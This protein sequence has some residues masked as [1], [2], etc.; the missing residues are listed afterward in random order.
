M[1]RTGWTLAAVL[2]A[3]VVAPAVLAGDAPKGDPY[4]LTTC[5]V[6]GKTLGAMG[7]PVAIEYEGREIRF[8]CKGCVAKFQA[9]PARYIE[10]IDAQIVKEQG[11]S[12]ALTTC[13]IS[14]KPLGEKPVERVIGNHLVR[15][16]CPDCVAAFE[17]DTAAGFAK[18]DAAV[19][20][21]RKKDYP[22]E[23]C[24]IS[25]AKLDAMGGGIDYVYGTHLVRFCCK[26]CIAKFLKDP[27][28]ALAKIDAARKA[29]HAEESEHEMGG[30]NEGGR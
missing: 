2:A 4:P 22:L 30:E 16:C 8:C 20:A 24:V 10:K 18:L 21:A 12:Y 19:I 3:V 27:A 25:G 11:P 14:G 23:T 5:P 28:A 15:F 1:L 13:P 17:K 26:G 9:D 29:H 7:D 6:T